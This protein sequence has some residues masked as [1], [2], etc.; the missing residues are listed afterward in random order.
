MPTEESLTASM[1]EAAKEMSAMEA[2]KKGDVDALE[3]ILET[4]GPDAFKERDP[5]GGHTL[6]HWAALTRGHTVDTCHESR[7]QHALLDDSTTTH[8][9]PW[10]AA[11]STPLPQHLD[12]LSFCSNIACHVH[13]TCELPPTPSRAAV[14]NDAS[15]FSGAC[16]AAPL[17]PMMRGRFT[18]C[19]SGSRRLRRVFDRLR[20]SGLYSFRP[21][22]NPCDLGGGAR[23]NRPKR[24]GR[25]SEF[26]AS[27]IHIT[28]PWIA[29]RGAA[30][31]AES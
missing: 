22:S 1:E 3:K 7:D 28:S 25:P 18:S 27:F 5:N 11:A 8:S 30:G 29:L 13:V 19:D 6:T 10:C 2:V 21:L 31:K 9:A 23:G 20:E 4:K 17:W 14:R 26:G 24:L 12:G 16:P 15:V